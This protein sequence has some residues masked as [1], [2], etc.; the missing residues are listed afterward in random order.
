MTDFAQFSPID[1]NK[2]PRRELFQHFQSDLPC[3]YAMTTELDI[4]H[5]LTVL[6]REKISLY[7]AVLWLLSTVVNRH[8][9]FRTAFNE[10]GVAGVWSFLN[11]S[12]T[13]FHAETETF[14]SLWTEYSEDFGAFW[15]KYDADISK[16]GNSTAFSPKPP[17]ENCFPVSAIP[18]T[19]FTGFN[20]HLQ[21][22]YDYLLPIFTTGKYSKRDG[23]ILMP[24]SS[25][26][27]HAVCDGFHL[28]RFL[29]ELQTECDG[30]VWKREE[31]L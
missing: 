28:S 16:Y 18:W 9:E 23:R 5:L 25:Q 27:H 15:R 21:K 4:T 19:S 3:T 11:A 1:M 10:E 14:S 22:G 12:Y 24:V 7:P 20:L 26:V 17:C 13:I 8:Q 2:Y 29:D 6:K 30:F 31:S